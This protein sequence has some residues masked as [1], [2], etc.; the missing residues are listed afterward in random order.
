MSRIA[1]ILCK[2][3]LADGTMVRP[4]RVLESIK[5]GKRLPE[6]RFANLKI[7]ARRQQSVLGAFSKADGS[8]QQ[9]AA[10]TP[11]G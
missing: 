7:A 6:A 10:D 1:W 3:Q 9:P 2:N 4:S 11:G 5:A 8:T